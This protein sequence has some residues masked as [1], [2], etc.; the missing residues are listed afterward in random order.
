MRWLRIMNRMRGRGEKDAAISW[1]SVLSGMPLSRP[2]SDDEYEKLRASF[3]AHWGSW[4]GGAVKG[5]IVHPH[6]TLH[7]AAMDAPGA[8]ENLR[9]VL[10]ELGVSRV[11]QL[12]EFG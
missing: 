9:S 1:V 2:L 4:Y 12:R 5:A 10:T 6:V 11:L 3:D 8:Y 7:T